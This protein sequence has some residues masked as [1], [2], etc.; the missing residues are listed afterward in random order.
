[1]AFLGNASLQTSAPHPA[2][3]PPVNPRVSLYDLS[4]EILIKIIGYI[5][6]QIQLKRA[7]R[8]Y[9]DRPLMLAM[10]CSKRLHKLTEIVLYSH[11]LEE[12]TGNQNSA[13]LFLKTILARPDLAARVRRYHGWA[14]DNQHHDNH[15]DV[16]SFGEKEWEKIK[17]RIKEASQD[18][19]E[20]S[21]WLKAIEE[22]DWEAITAL[23]LSI[24]PNIQDLKFKGWSY[25][26]DV[27]PN[28]LRY[29]SRARLLQEQGDLINPLSMSQLKRVR[30][31]YW[32]T[33]GGMSPDL[34]IPLLSLPSV[35]IFWARM[36]AGRDIEGE[37]PWLHLK[38]PH[39]KELSLHQVNMQPQDIE[40]V[41]K[42]FPA[43]ET[44]YYCNGDSGYITFEPPRIMVAIK[45]LRPC[46][47]SLTVSN[48]A[49]YGSSILENYPIGSL[50]DFRSLRKVTLDSYTLTG[51]N[52]NQNLE[53]F[54]SHQDLLNS[55]PPSIEE[56]TLLSCNYNEHVPIQISTLISQ[57]AEQFPA[58]KRIDLGWEK[59]KYPDKPSPPEPFKFPGFTEKA[60]M[61]LLAE[62]EA[63]GVEMVMKT[64]PPQPKYIH[65]R[66]NEKDHVEE[67]GGGG[68][69]FRKAPPEVTHYVP[70]P[71]DDYERLCE[72]HGC[73]PKTGRRPGSMF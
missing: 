2:E 11:Y 44:L 39:I 70:Y 5:P 34:L 23:I 28:L 72:E 32:D 45:H 15:L 55:L 30:K 16:Q 6:L 10:L 24:T 57:K 35:E 14:T 1:M 3:T 7:T 58:L 64:V 38:F 48:A 19:E 62:L 31:D 73:D 51:G 26:N 33:D 47:Q 52:D 22:G 20:A 36:V 63:A 9:G 21:V 65:Y 46:L 37:C 25:T 67:Q 50:T 54:Q 43:L 68:T 8:P 69:L 40:K 60:A 66:V 53:G 27:Y 42:S 59:I 12:F 49:A 29:F 13:P 56:L 71:Y 4:N 41:L 18:A 61:A 17:L